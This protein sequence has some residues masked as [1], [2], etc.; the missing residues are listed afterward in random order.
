MPDMLPGAMQ[1]VKR[2]V[3]VC[4]MKDML[5]QFMLKKIRGAMEGENIGL[6]SEIVTVSC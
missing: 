1:Y 6:R 3:P 4:I 5:P 2:W